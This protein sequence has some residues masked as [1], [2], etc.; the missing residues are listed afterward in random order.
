MKE[1]I[2]LNWS[3]LTLLDVALWLDAGITHTIPIY[4]VRDFDLKI[5]VFV[6]L[7]SISLLIHSNLWLTIF[8]TGW[9]HCIFLIYDLQFLLQF[10]CIVFKML[11][12]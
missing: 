4:R 7:N 2:S 3:F 11:A 5:L 10:G 6:L 9:L 1:T 8:I 12:S